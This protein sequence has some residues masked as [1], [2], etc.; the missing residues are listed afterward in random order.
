MLNHKEFLIGL[1]DLKEARARKKDYED[2]T[3]DV[4]E[5]ISKLVFDLVDYM[6]NTDHLSV[7]IDGLGTCSLTHSKKYSVDSENPEIFE[8]W[9]NEHGEMENVMSVHAMKV[10]GYYKEKLENNEDLPPGIKTYI[11][12]NITIRSIT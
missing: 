4:N 5:Q 12:S 2:L 1:E 9:M 8:S 7:K 11:K 3:K 10:H 6:E